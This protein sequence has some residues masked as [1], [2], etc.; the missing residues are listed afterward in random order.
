MVMK[1]R[2]TLDDL[3][4][5]EYSKLGFF[6]ELQQK[7]AELEVSNFELAR[8]QRQIQ[9]IL[10]GI[11]DVMVV[12]SLDFHIISVNHEFR[13]VFGV[14]EPEGKL[15]YQVFRHAHQPCSPCPLITASDDN[16]ICRHSSI[17]PVD[18]KN[19]HFEITAS[20]LRNPDGKPCLILMLM[21][22]VTLE[23]ELQAKYYQTQQMATIG[24]LA[25]GVAHEINNPLTAISGF[26]EGLK[27]RLPRLERRIDKELAEDFSEYLGIILKECQRCQEIVQTLLTFGRQTSFECC[28]VNLNALLKDTLKLLQNQLKH[29]RKDIVRVV[30]D[31]ALPSIRGDESQLK[32]VIL[33]LL[34]NAFDAT[35]E[36]GVIILRT[37]EENQ[38]WVVFSVEDSGCGISSEHMDK[39]FEPFFTT[40]PV[41][42]GVGIGLST[43]YNIVSK[44]GG[45]ILVESEIG[46]GSTFIVRLP[47]ENHDGDFQSHSHLG[48]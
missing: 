29:Y 15:C 7:I 6:K 17:Y 44:H 26:A 14:A 2:P 38:N 45:E 13:N 25:A 22:D 11:S 19:R 23:K 10:D 18:G 28:S 4:G 16:Q 30:A 41:G 8:R 33:N 12:L 32:Q 35:Q 42:K 40:K 46:R 47:R 39:L 3:I 43:C 48:G 34:F 21:R 9:A 1:S 5:V 27:R 37:Y 36:K 24:V 20:P 31:D